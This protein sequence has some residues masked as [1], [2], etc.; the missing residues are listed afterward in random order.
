MI[1]VNPRRPA[2]VLSGLGTVL[3]LGAA[4][5]MAALPD[6]ARRTAV[7]SAAAAPDTGTPRFTVVAS[8]PG[9]ASGLIFATPQSPKTPA[10]AHGPQILDDKGRPVW[11][12]RLPT[13]EY[14]TDL[15]V[16]R[17]RGK[18]VLTWW[19]GSATNT[20]I[21]KGVGYIADSS[22][23]VIAT[24]KPEGDHAPDLHEFELT[25]R[26]TALVTSYR[27]VPY[28]LTPVGGPRDGQVVDSVVEEIDVAT[29]RRVLRWS[30]LAHVPIT[31]SDVPVAL[32]KGGPFDYFHVNSAGLDTDGNLL[33]SGRT[34]STVYKVH[35][36]TGKIIWRLGGRHSTFRLGVGVR[37]NWQHDAKADGRDTY[38]I[39]DNGS[40]AGAPGW[41]SRVVRVRIDP[42]R[43]TTEFVRQDVH[44]ARPSVENEGGAQALPGGGTFVSW[45]SSSRISEF[46]RSGRLVWDATLPA[47]WSSYRAYRAEWNGS[48]AEAPTASVA[49]DGTVHAIWNGATAAAR[50]R[51][52]GGDSPEALKP[53]GEAP[54][55][56]FDTAV[57]PSSMPRLVKVEAL[58]RTG[59]SIGTSAVVPTGR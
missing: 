45:G 1:S 55:N 51:V 19:Q 35:R 32:A 28:D 58:D 27:T 7:P 29:G 21:G 44:D 38:R 20:G 50:W 18:P 3:V 5:A 40:V 57:R 53:V 47:G 34:T 24:V 30:S 10:A 54:W 8:R 9:K 41:E 13:G 23:R 59:R 14:A 17:Y 26:G 11:F 42:E 48:P 36:T 33:I 2:V 25:P 37:F 52:L 31:Q 43:R 12:K 39:F 49:A 56:G 22:Y 4:S 6:G 15:R 16:Q 46:S